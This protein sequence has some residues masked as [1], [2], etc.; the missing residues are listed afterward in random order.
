MLQII[1]WCFLQVELPVEVFITSQFVCHIHL[2]PPNAFL[3]LDFDV[4]LTTAWIVCLE[5]NQ[6]PAKQLMR[7]CDSLQSPKYAMSY[8]RVNM[9][10]HACFLS[11]DRDRDRAAAGVWCRVS[12]AQRAMRKKICT[13]NVMHVLSPI[14]MRVKST[15]ASHVI[16]SWRKETTDS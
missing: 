11:R 16:F 3:R 1:L 12:G 6:P 15:L 8:A 5:P 7:L 10:C 13:C 14:L 2:L 4:R 9:Q